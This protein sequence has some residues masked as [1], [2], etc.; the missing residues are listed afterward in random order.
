MEK[1]KG[2]K[3]IVTRE[4]ASNAVTILDVSIEEAW[5][6]VKLAK[7]FS[8]ISESKQLE[9]LDLPNS[10]LV[11]NFKTTSLSSSLSDVH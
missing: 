6:Y 4:F 10:C 2:I 9:I 3:Y 1:G 7:F 11:V 5:F 8:E